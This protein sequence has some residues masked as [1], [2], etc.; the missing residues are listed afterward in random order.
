MKAAA[1]GRVSWAPMVR[2]LGP[3]EDPVGVSR[4]SNWDR[5]SAKASPST[6]GVVAALRDVAEEI[7]EVLS[8]RARGATGGGLE[9]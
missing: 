6:V 1:T 2:G 9:E 3:R 7:D 5:L 4:L 8:A